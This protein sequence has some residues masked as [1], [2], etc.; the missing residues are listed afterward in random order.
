MRVG[1]A[2]FY[3]RRHVYGYGYEI[4]LAEYSGTTVRAIATGVTMEELDPEG[5]AVLI[6]RP[7]IIVLD[8]REATQLMDELWNAGVRPGDIG[9]VGERTALK[10]AR[11]WAQSV[12]NRLLDRGV[13]S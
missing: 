8:N 13:G 4:Y 7:P 1:E 12:A 3:I 6:E 5:P 9:S 11:D 10:E 2:K